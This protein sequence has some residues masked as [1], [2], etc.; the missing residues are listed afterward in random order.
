[1]NPDLHGVVHLFDG[2]HHMLWMLGERVLFTQLTHHSALSLLDGY[3]PALGMLSKNLASE[4][5]VGNFEIHDFKWPLL[6]CEVNDI[7]YLME[8]LSHCIKEKMQEKS[9]EYPVPVVE[10]ALEE[11]QKNEEVKATLKLL[12]KKCSEIKQERCIKQ[13]EDTVSVYRENSVAFNDLKRR[14]TDLKPLINAVS[15]FSKKSYEQ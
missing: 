11:W 5:V 12:Q 13:L 1:M 10:K 15:E 8:Q 9:K 4:L 6:F 3:L 7:S 14:R 2:K